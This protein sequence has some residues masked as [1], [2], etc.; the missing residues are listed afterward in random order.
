MLENTK[1]L[2]RTAAPEMNDTK[3]YALVGGGCFWCV[4]AVYQRLKGVLKVESGYAGGHVKNP[5]YREVS[6]KTTGHVEVALIT[7]NPNETSYEEILEVFFRTHNPT[8]LNRQGNDIGP[9][10]R[11]EIFYYNDEQKAIAEKM[12]HEYAPQYWDEPIVTAVT[13]F[14]NYYPAEAYHQNYYQDNTQQ[15]YCMMVVRPKVEKFEKI[16]KD[17]MKN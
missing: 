11:S 4:E 5:P 9:Q 7:F 16:F 6:N 12:V 15:G 17:K 13:E 1:N 10:Y 8:T 14:V 3:Q 2:P